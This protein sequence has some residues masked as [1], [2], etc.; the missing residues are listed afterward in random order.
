M[1][2]YI[3]NQV[4]KLMIRKEITIKRANIL[5]LGITF[6]ENCPD[7]RNTKVIDVL[8]ALKEYEVNIKIYDPWASPLEVQSAYGWVSQRE[9]NTEEC[10][11][12]VILAVAHGEFRSLDYGK[13]VNSKSVIYD[14][15]GFIEGHVDG[16]L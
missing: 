10:F 5:V 7:V 15:K 1:G 3:A 4:V 11:D 2:E 9:L 13:L 14:V 12:V 16:R 6:K 8:N